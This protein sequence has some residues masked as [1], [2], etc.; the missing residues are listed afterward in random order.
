MATAEGHEGNRDG[1]PRT[2]RVLISL[3]LSL[4]VLNTVDNAQVSTIDPHCA[5]ITSIGGAERTEGEDSLL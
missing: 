4:S 2:P 1:I 3:C 5:N